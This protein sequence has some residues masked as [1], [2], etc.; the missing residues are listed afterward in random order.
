[1][2]AGLDAASLK[3]MVAKLNAATQTVLAR[4]QALEQR[5]EASARDVNGLQTMLQA[6][7]HEALT[8][9]LT[10]LANRKHFDEELRRQMRNAAATTSRW[11]SFLATSITSNASTILG[12]TRSAI[13]SSGSWR[14]C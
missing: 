9:G 13:P 10:G 8:D 11:R 1:M 3:S 14:A 2:E 6:A 4:N 7:R 5:M 12:D